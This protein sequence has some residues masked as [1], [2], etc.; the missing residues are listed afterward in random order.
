MG[1]SAVE[2]GRRLLND[3]ELENVIGGGVTVGADGYVYYD[4]AAM[5]DANGMQLSVTA[6]WLAKGGDQIISGEEIKVYCRPTCLKREPLWENFLARVRLTERGMAVERHYYRCSYCGG[7]FFVR[8]A[9][10]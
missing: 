8:V 9:A 5:C 6:E 7:V 2:E 4:D 10:N 1:V 3:E